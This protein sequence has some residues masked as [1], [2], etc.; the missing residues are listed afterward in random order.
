MARTPTAQDIGSERTQ[1]VASQRRHTWRWHLQRRAFLLM[2]A[3]GLGV[4]LIFIVYPFMTSFAY[5]FYNW[6]GVG[7]MSDFIGLGNYIY[8]LTSKDF[9]IFFYRAILHN[10]Y[11]FGMAMVLTTIVGMILAYLLTTIPQRAARIFQVLYFLPYVIPPVVVAFLTSIYLEPNFGVLSTVLQGTGLSS[12]D[13]PWL[14]SETLALPTITVI[15]SW[16]SVGFAMLIFLAAMVGLPIDILEAARIDGASPFQL[17]TKIV[18]PLIRPTFI[19]LMT[20]TFIGSFGTFDLI[21]VLEGTQAGPNY[22]TDVSGT[23]FYRTAFGGFGATAQN[24]GL[25]TALAV[26]AF[27]IV[28]VVSAILVRLQKRYTVQY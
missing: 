15:A 21:Y 27:I 10:L 26:V 20:L 25:A 18:F 2:L 6:N 11:L 5:S 23:L 13:L 3:P 22:A 28:M 17:F 7:P 12:W 24:M 19:T 4:Y 14:G 16:A 1:P 9:S 8:T